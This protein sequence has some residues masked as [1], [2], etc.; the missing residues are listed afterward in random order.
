MI[1]KKFVLLLLAILLPVAANAQSQVCRTGTVPA[2]TP[3]S[4]F[5]NNNDGTVMDNKTSL[6]W[7][8]C[9][10]GQAW[11]SVTG[12]CDGSVA[13]YTW[14]T[15]LERAQ[16]VNN[17]EG[18]FASYRDWRVPNIKELASIVEEQCYEPAINLTV[19]PNT[20]PLLFWSSSP[21]AGYYTY[22]VHFVDGSDSRGARWD[23]SFVRLV[24]DR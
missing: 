19:F 16:T 4:R 17:D 24:R 8:K 7:K 20:P 13:T 23:D 21:D 3:T 9:S 5:V 12:D 1:L 10:E 15:A 11:N 18:G 6:M 2:T 14:K 22:N